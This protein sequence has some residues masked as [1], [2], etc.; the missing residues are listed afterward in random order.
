M[1]KIKRS[2]KVVDKVPAIDEKQLAFNAIV[3]NS[4]MT[5]DAFT[6]FERDCLVI[7]QNASRNSNSIGDIRTLNA[8]YFSVFI[9]TNLNSNLSRI[10]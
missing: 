8:L 2:L 1:A 9:F 4:S 10:F 6:N 5:N 7:S 3:G